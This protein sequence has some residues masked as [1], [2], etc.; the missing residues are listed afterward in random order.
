MS[1][2]SVLTPL[3]LPCHRPNGQE[4]LSVYPTLT[5]PTSAIMVVRPGGPHGKV[6]KVRF[7]RNHPRKALYV[8]KSIEGPYAPQGGGITENPQEIRGNRTFPSNHQESGRKMEIVA[9]EF[10]LVE[11]DIRDVTFVLDYSTQRA[12]FVDFNGKV[13]YQEVKDGRCKP[14][15]SGVQRKTDK[16]RKPDVQARIDRIYAML[17]QPGNKPLKPQMI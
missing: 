16:R 4:I 8:E 12:Y 5:P 6:G 14:T 17:L 2:L 3:A 15:V 7:A 9:N 13:R 1:D 11:K 10:D